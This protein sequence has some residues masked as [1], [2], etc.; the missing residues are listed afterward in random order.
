MSKN[1]TSFKKS[2]ITMKDMGMI[3]VKK[4]M[5]MLKIKY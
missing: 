4:Q 2:N 1:K 3:P 5:E